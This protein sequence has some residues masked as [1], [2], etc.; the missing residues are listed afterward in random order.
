[1]S[2]TATPA[3][4]ACRAAVLAR[5]WGALA[6]EPIAGLVQRRQEGHDLAVTLHDGRVLRG[7]L[8]AA[9]P[10]AVARDGFAVDL[11]GCGFADP[12]ELLRAMRLPGRSQRLAQELANSVENLAL[13]RSGQPA[14]DGGEP[15]LTRARRADDPL[16]YL[17]QCVVDGHPLHP[18]CRTRMG[19]TRDEVLAYAPEH[20]PVVALDLVPVPPE[21]WLGH[22]CPPV[23]VVHPWQREHV[24][25]R[26]GFLRPSGRVAKARPLMSLR[27]LA[28]DRHRHVKT[29]VD[30]QMTSAVRTV[31]AAAIHNAPIVSALLLGLV[32]RAPELRILPEPAS[33]AV[34]VDGEPCRSLAVVHRRVPA[35][36]AGEVALPLA[37]LAAPSPADGAPI[38]TEVVG[39]AYGKD[40]GRFIEALAALTIPPLLRMLDLGVALEAHG[41]NLLVVLREQRLVGLL[42]RDFGGIRISPR[43]L[44]GHGIEVPALRGELIEDDPDVLRTKL[45]AAVTVVLGELIAV[46]SR[47]CDLDPDEAWRRVAMACRPLSRSSADA[48]VLFAATLPVKATTAMRLAADPLEDLWTGLPNPMAGLG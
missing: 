7:E 16:A 37:A 28:L 18:C 40:P 41:Q 34:L 11:G 17:E 25:D 38:V 2:H 48:G 42:Y 46:L 27:T 1:M 30:V 3:T 31:S 20:R 4:G 33:G 36:G 10:Y 5:L 19:L 8:A 39:S 21:R 35:L 29:A 24:L 15:A 45:F 47:C 26:Y 32:R 23:L 43:R 44:A 22:D 12:A 13:A 6:R 14:P 9:A